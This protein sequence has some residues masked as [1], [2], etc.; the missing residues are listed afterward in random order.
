MTKDFAL[1]ECAGVAGHGCTRDKIAMPVL[2]A[3]M[4][5]MK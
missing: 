4:N 3:D 2:H 1:R 5:E